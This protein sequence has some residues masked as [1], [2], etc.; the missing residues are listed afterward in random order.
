MWKYRSVFLPAFLSFL[1][2]ALASA[3]VNV[4]NEKNAGCM[5]V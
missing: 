5:I 4:Y 3:F 1:V 2:V